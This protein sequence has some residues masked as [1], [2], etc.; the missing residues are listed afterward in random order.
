[1]RKRL[2]E[3]AFCAIVVLSVFLLGVIHAFYLQ[4]RFDR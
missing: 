1:M 2:N 3:I 4:G